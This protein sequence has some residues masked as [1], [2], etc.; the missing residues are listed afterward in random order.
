[1]YPFV[2]MAFQAWLHRNDGPLEPYGT[3]VSHHICWPWD[4]DFWMELNNG[5]ALTLYDMGRVQMSARNGV[6]AMLRRK[7]WGIAVAGASVRYRRRIRAFDRIEMRTRALGWDDRFL[8][9]EQSMWKSDGDC[10]G[11]VLI[12]G[13]VTSARG[14]V[15]PA[16]A[17]AEA[18]IAGPS[19]PL[20]DWV[21]AWIAAEARRPWPPMGG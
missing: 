18:G 14:I 2:R 5:R 1:M 9:M 13:A 6:T 17:M 21:L 8:Y 16:E 11:H 12:R 3:H 7:G 10:A 20:P 19:R 15:P 4:L